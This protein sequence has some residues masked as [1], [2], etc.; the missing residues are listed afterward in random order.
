VS[1]DMRVFLSG[2]TGYSG[3]A[4]AA[5]LARR[6]ARVQA[7]VRRKVTI[8]GCET[9]V[10]DLGDV[11]RFASS[12]RASP[13]V[14]HLAS[15]RGET[16]EIVTEDVLNTRDLI[17]AWSTGPFVYPS[18]AT[19]YGIPES[20]PLK[21]DH[22]FNP[23]LPYDH[24]KIAIEKDVQS[25]A[26]NK[27][28]GPAII[29]RPSLIFATNDRRADRQF[30]SWI[31]ILCRAR[32]KFVFDSEQGLET[33]GASFVGEEDYGRAIAD[34]LSLQKS[35]AY[36]VASGFGTW[37]ALIGAFDKQ[38]GSRSEFVIRAGGRA[39]ASDEIRL[40]QSRTELDTSAFA[41]ATGFTPRQSMEEL[42]E[43]F[44]VEER[45]HPVC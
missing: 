1:G 17:A 9:V 32:K 44:A 18:H 43:R 35:G 34:S 42:V 39:E 33:Y 22:P 20:Q 38:L 29:I 30:F 11:R 40:G 13:G 45:Q 24:G 14:I 2:A 26:F 28:R 36:H 5:E 16:K 21:E 19:V 41:D 12:I 23:L 15:P 6:G 8:P 3:Q 31:Y 27:G 4:V 37:R 7:L 25:A 10:G